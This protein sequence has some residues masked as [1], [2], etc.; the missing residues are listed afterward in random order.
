MNK[1]YT[2][3]EVSKMFAGS[4]NELAKTSLKYN[5]TKLLDPECIQYLTHYEKEFA[6]FRSRKIKLLEIGVKD[7]ESLKMWKDYM[8][9]DSKVYGI[10]LNPVPLASFNESG[11]VIL[12]GDQTDIHFLKTVQEHGP[13]DIII[14]DGGHTMFQMRTSFE[15]LFRYALS[16]NGLYVIED[17]G[18]SYWYRWSGG[19]D[20]QG[21]IMS[22]LKELVDGINYRF[23]KGNRLDYVPIPPDNA[24]DADYFDEHIT[25]I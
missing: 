17:L 20:R 2:R 18:T 16:D 7:G 8:H 13:F 4:N 21:T 10:E 11:I 19:I 15:Y 3:E 5:T 14:D 23:W 9:P 24:V 22:K 1:R 6:E 12:Y 25:E